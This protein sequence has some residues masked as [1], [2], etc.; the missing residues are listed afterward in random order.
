MT[1]GLKMYGSDSLMRDREET[2]GVRT[3]P[4]VL[5]KVISQFLDFLLLPFAYVC[6]YY[7]F[8]DARG[9]FFAYWGLFILINMSIAGLANLIAVGTPVRMNIC[10]R[11]R[12][13]LY[14]H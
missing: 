2:G 6:G 1:S 4:Y 5:G 13:Y 11:A 12:L 8:V 14:V 3:T 7:P 10:T 9:G